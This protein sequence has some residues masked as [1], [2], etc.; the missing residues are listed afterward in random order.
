MRRTG[1]GLSVAQIAA[2]PSLRQLTVGFAKTDNTVVDVTGM[3]V[4]ILANQRYIFRAWLPFSL[5]GAVSGFQFAINGPAAP[6]TFIT[7]AICLTAGT[8]FISN[9]LTTIGGVF[10]NALAAAATHICTFEGSIVN[11]ANAGTLAV[12]AGQLVTNASPL[13][14]LAGAYFSVSMVG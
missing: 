9:T 8:T 1:N 6:T 10:S 12:Q 14:V 13:T 11:G 7:S 5:G 2:I 3:S 4:P